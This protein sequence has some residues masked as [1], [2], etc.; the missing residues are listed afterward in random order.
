MIY[1]FGDS[2][3]P[4][5]SEIALASWNKLDGKVADCYKL[6]NMI[7]Y[8][9]GKF[10]VSTDFEKNISILEEITY[11]FGLKTTIGKVLKYLFSPEAN[12]KVAQKLLRELK[13]EIHQEETNLNF[14]QMSPVVDF[15]GLSGIIDVL[16]PQFYEFYKNEIRNEIIFYHLDKEKNIGLDGLLGILYK[17]VEYSFDDE[18]IEYIIAKILSSL[19]DVEKGKSLQFMPGYCS[20]YLINGSA[21]VIKVLMTID[22]DRFSEIILSLADSLCFEFAQRPGYIDG[23][24]GCIDAL[25]DVYYWTKNKKYLFF[26]EKQLT[27]VSIYWSHDSIETLEF[28]YL[29]QRLV[30]CMEG[31]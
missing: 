31:I 23:M 11:C 6:G 17:M 5:Q 9:A 3:I 14:F 15:K 27:I 8:L 4:I 19:R 24:L 16:C 29:Y 2:F 20:P 1:S 22:I 10:Q 21:G 13:V 25:L 7:L 18:I 28:V 30:D 26:A 12:I